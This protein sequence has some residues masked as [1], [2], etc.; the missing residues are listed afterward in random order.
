MAALALSISAP[1][2]R[3]PLIATRRI[4]FPIA[5]N[6]FSRWK[7]SQVD[8][9]IAIS[10]AVADRLVADRIPRS[11]IEVVHEGVDVERLEHLPAA[12]VHAAFY[13]PTHSPVIGN[14]GAL[15]SQKNQ[16]DLIEAA[17]FVVRDVPD[18]RFGDPR[19]RRTAR[20]ART[21]DQAPAPRTP[22]DAGRLPH[23][24]HGDDQGLRHLRAQLRRTRA[25]ARRSW[26]PW[27]PRSRPSPRRLAACPR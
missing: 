8:A 3:P 17:A 24:R 19:R 12:N 23:R 9:F 26:M 6:S 11:R 13:L 4:E 15:T 2:P 18:A 14:V 20:G 10:A 7:Y 5:R 27:P 16:H 22:R 25:C 21:P 1:E